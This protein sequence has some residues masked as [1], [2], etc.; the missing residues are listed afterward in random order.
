M[1][2]PTQACDGVNRLA[3][4]DE[5][6]YKLVLVLVLMLVLVFVLVLLTLPTCHSALTDYGVRQ[7]LPTC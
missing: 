6:S 7:S 4:T 2:T 1:L 5:L 3:E